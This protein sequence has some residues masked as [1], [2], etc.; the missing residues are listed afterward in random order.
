MLQTGHLNASIYNIFSVEVIFRA[1]II[2]LT[3]IF[4]SKT[5]NCHMDDI[6]ERRELNSMP[7]FYHDPGIFIMSTFYDEM[8]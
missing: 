2:P 6:N 8:S 7:H 5:C 1:T 3:F 4:F